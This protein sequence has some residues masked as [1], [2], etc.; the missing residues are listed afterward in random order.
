MDR[1]HKY[2]GAIVVFRRV[3][4]VVQR[5]SSAPVCVVIRDEFAHRRIFPVGGP[6]IFVDFVRQEGAPCVC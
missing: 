4:A 6:Q 2:L 3:L 1:R 5:I